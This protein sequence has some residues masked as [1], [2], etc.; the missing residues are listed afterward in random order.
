MIL[1]QKISFLIEPALLKTLIIVAGA[2]I[3][4]IV[5]LVLVMAWF[6]RQARR[7]GMGG[8]LF[9]LL[10]IITLLGVMGG[11]L[12]LG[13]GLVAVFIDPDIVKLPFMTA[14]KEDSGENEVAEVK[15]LDEEKQ[16]EMAMETDADFSIDPAEGFRLVEA[17]LNRLVYVEQKEGIGE[18]NETAARFVVQ[19]KRGVPPNIDLK[20]FVASQVKEIEGFFREAIE[21]QPF[22]VTINRLQGYELQA[23]ARQTTPKRS[24]GMYL[25][26][27]YDENDFYLMLG[28][29]DETMIGHY[30]MTFK[31]MAYSFKRRFM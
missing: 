27:L 6:G 29:A 25:V 24:V 23:T 16:L 3:L 28:V 7:G 30:R 8:L 14:E 21:R 10:Q 18:A 2:G 5:V 13:V 22:P 9:R 12:V 11:S 15:P 4:C 26:I 20:E 19:L 17:D 31:N 1:A